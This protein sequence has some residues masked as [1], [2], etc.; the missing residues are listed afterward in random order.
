MQLRRTRIL[1][2]LVL[3]ASLLSGC[4]AQKPNYVGAA[5]GGALL[6][7]STGAIVGSLIKNGSIV[8]SAG[9]G[10]ALGIPAG[11][12]LVVAMNAIDGPPATELD[13]SDEI[14]ANQDQIFRLERDIEDLRREIDSE[15]TRG[16][17]VNAPR[18]RVYNGQSN[19]NPYR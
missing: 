13:R 3:G 8:K 1:V 10:A 18:A 16:R 19:F 2:S 12:A 9:L 6:G 11:L 15:S 17:F 4:M 7:A 14:K 5:S